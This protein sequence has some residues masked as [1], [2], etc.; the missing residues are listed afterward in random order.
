MLI[1]T[2]F[3]D[4]A[5]KMVIKVTWGYEGPKPTGLESLQEE[6]E[7]PGVC[8]PRAKSMWRHSKEEA[9]WKPRK[10]A[11]P[12]TKPAG[13]LILVLQPPKLWENKFLLLKPLVCGIQLWQPG[14]TNTPCA[15]VS[16]LSPF[17]SAQNQSF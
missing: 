11:S 5:F 9:I 4:G 10:E 16:Y 12:A 1:L 15:K 8:V 17:S 3:E 2:I 14:L 7:L 13:A 6:E